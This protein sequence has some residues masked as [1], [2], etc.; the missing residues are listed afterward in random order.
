MGSSEIEKGS[1][2]LSLNCGLVQYAHVNLGPWLM[3]V[4]GRKMDI[5]EGESK[6]VDH[7]LNDAVVK[8]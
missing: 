4:S 1:S 8:F 7:L 3:L 5:I 6:N 2:C